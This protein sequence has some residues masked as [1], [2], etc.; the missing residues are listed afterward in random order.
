MSNTIKMTKTFEIPVS[1]DCS[2]CKCREITV[3]SGYAFKTCCAFDNTESCKEFLK[4]E[5]EKN[6]TSV[7]EIG[8]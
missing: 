7:E 8:C 2:I 6:N 1:G 5:A 3:V 4:A